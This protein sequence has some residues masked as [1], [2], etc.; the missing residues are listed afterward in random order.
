MEFSFVGPTLRRI[1]YISISVH[2]DNC[3]NACLNISF[4]NISRA[5]IMAA[6]HC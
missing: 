1:R 2:K 3:E 5:H 4:A 6:S